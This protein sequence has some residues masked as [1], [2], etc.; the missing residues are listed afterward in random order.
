MKI[1]SNYVD[2]VGV[3]TDPD[4]ISSV[5][6]LLTRYNQLKETANLYKLEW[7]LD[8]VSTEQLHILIEK[9]EAK[10]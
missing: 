4:N 1:E 3:Q 8:T 7:H 5:E 2:D 6:R 10:L 9:L